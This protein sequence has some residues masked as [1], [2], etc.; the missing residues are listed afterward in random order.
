M[1]QDTS[2]CD[3][4]LLP[5]GTNDNGLKARRVFGSAHVDHFFSLQCFL[6]HT[7]QDRMT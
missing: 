1:N 5:I 2:N 3:L 4:H 6:G 7:Q